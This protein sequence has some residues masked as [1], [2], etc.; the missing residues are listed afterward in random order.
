[1]KEIRTFRERVIAM[2]NAGYT[3]AEIAEIYGM[4]EWIIRIICGR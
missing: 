4:K 3:C 1:M 2:N